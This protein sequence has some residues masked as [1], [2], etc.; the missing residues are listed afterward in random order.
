MRVIGTDQERLRAALDARL[1][2]LLDE[3]AAGLAEHWPDYANFLESDRSA[4]ADAAAI[5]VQR[6]VA[7]SEGDL[8]D[9]D[10]PYGAETLHAVFEQVG[11]QQQGEG[12]SL[13]RLLT[14]FQFG[15]RVAWRHVAAVALDLGRPPDTL[16]LLADA[17]FVFV[18]QLSFAATRGYLQ[19]QIDDSR[20]RERH[21]EELAEM[22]LSGR[23]SE[24]AIQ[25]AAISCG[26]RI[27]AKAAVVIVDPDDDEA[28]RT[29]DRLGPD[30]LPIRRPDLYGTIVPDPDVA[31]RQVD[32]A[33]RLVGAHA[34][35]GYPVPL[36]R[37]PRSTEVAQAA[38]ELRAT[39]A[40][41]GDP[42]FAE[43]HIDT[44]IVRRDGGLVDALTHQALAPLEELPAD[45]R[46]R[47]T[48]TLTAWLYHQGDHRAMAR[49]LNI[50]PQ[51]VRYRMRQL[52]DA[53]G[54]SLD[55]PRSRARLFLALGWRTG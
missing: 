1:D 12:N 20:A 42:I 15:A 37:L 31:G 29:L 50:H 51:T 22:L 5:F 46:E 17:V 54:E 3:V 14:A 52:R 13:F 8:S 49:E 40:L 55:D 30:A 34:V 53:F 48:E 25:S 47:L 7:M 39:G 27:P 16:A 9:H 38:A 36:E 26:W 45:A 19:A 18:N 32:L 10:E 28:R 33:R 23:A 11:R 21:R 35:I 41:E 6:L 24:A 4:I 2:A 43:D 44:I